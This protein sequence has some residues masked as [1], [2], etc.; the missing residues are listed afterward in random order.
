MAGKF[1]KYIAVLLIVFLML[2][3][4]MFP[5]VI[6]A[7]ELTPTPTVEQSQEQ[8]A[9]QPSETN[10]ENTSQTQVDNVS[11]TQNS[12]DVLSNTGDNTIN[13]TP[14]PTPIEVTPAQEEQLQEEEPQVQPQPEENTL[15]PQEETQSSPQENLQEA[16]NENPNQDSNSLNI[17]N[18]ASV[19]NSI[20]S[21]GNSGENEIATASA[22]VFLDTN[23][24]SC[25]TPNGENASINT[26]NAVSETTIDNSVNTNS[27]N[28]EVVYN[29]INI[30]VDQNG[31]L[32]LSDPFAIASTMIPEHPNDEVINV[33]FTDINNY[34]YL[35][36]N[37]NSYANTGNNTINS[38]NYGDE[39]VINTGN[40]YSI[41][42]LL[43]KVN[44]TIINSTIHIV[45]INIFGSLNG[46]IIL[47]DFALANASCA[48]CGVSLIASNSATVVNNVDSEA[49]S[50][51]NTVYGNGNI[52]T[53]DAAS[54]VNNLNIVNANFVN[55]T[56]QGLFI[57]LVGNWDGNFIGWN[58][59]DPESGGATLMFYLA[60]PLLSDSSSCPTC[61]VGDVSIYNSA[62]V[63]N[64]VTSLASSGGNTVN[65]N[66]SINSGSAFSSISLINFINA[67]FINSIGFFGFLNI[68]GDWTGDI[69][70]KSNFDKLNQEEP[71]VEPEIQ[72]ESQ[73]SDPKQEEGGQLSIT[74]AN[75]VGAFVY[76]GDTVTFFIKVK[77]TGSGKV[78]GTKVRLS[79]VKDG[80]VTGEG[81]FN[82]GDIEGGKSLR[83]ITGLVL[84]SNAKPGDYIAVA[85][86][87]GNVGPDNSLVSASSESTFK[88]FGKGSP[89]QAILTAN[90][91]NLPP[92]V[93]GTKSTDR[94]GTQGMTRDMLYLMLLVLV[95]STYTGIRVARKREYV[96]DLLYKKTTLKE[97]L[98]T[99][100]M[101]LL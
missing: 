77:N 31:N 40:A 8:Q 52:S 25:S 3:N 26:G 35:S 98:H 22:D 69:G 82:L 78:Y 18:N 71:K 74:S 11:E 81:L 2:Y 79:L 59:F 38:S 36:N 96:W 23:N 100:R 84:S 1:K 51:Q 6:F 85:K 41:V 44:F 90:T 39:A 73:P 47:P 29:T 42:S 34:V 10:V 86:A 63:E 37:V 20:N 27:I 16:N 5:A 17:E 97:K 48:T 75:N 61:A 60:G 67:N 45:S 15:Q 53:G 58:A 64:N 80:I 94:L 83:L 12:V 49:I 14:T 101:F 72:T 62:Y 32:N 57:N 30:F 91:Q 88:I 21:K 66:G 28:S 68:F 92:A 99:L 33:S 76:P 89:T 19:D 4:T 56:V 9:E 70:G 93:L 87:Q 95:M 55:T 7:D 54:L 13:P 50:G 46:N 43:N 65:G 24:N